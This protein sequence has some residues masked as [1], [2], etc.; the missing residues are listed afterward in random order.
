MDIYQDIYQDIEGYLGYQFLD[1]DMSSMHIQIMDLHDTGIR[2]VALLPMFPI[3][4]TRI[5]IKSLRVS[6][7]RS[8]PSFKTRF[9]S[10]I[11][12]TGNIRKSMQGKYA[13]VWCPSSLYALSI[14][15]HLFQ[16]SGSSESNLSH[17][18]G[19]ESDR[20]GSAAFP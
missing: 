10:E 17:R 6:H 3:R 18:S 11:P 20:E 9:P 19:G 2:M 12:T 7:G 5:R 15:I 13:G 1:H 14:S 16:M 4:H 8:W